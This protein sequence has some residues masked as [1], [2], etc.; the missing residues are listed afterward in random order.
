MEAALMSCKRNALDL[1][2]LRTQNVV[3]VRASVGACNSDSTESLGRV[4]AGIPEGKVPG[5]VTWTGG[6]G[7]TS[8]RPSKFFPCTA[9][10]RGQLQISHQG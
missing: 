2:F 7:E 6:A 5:A 3:G 4:G 10:D 8:R 1:Q 9:P